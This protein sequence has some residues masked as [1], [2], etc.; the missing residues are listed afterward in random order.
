MSG[1]MS[2]ERELSV[3]IGGFDENFQ[4]AAY[5]FD[6][7]FA[8]RA[9]R[10]GARVRFCPEASLRHLRAERG[11][12]RVHGNHLASA[13]PIHGV[14][15]YYFALLHGWNPSTAWYMARRMVREVATRFHLRHPWFI[16][17]KLVGEVR[18]F[19]WALKLKRQGPR[20]LASGGREPTDPVIL[21]PAQRSSVVLDGT[22]RMN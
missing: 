1:H 2:V 6:T 16:P 13:D 12:T 15:D 9:I 20:H 11:G 14:G 19:L 21:E 17:V 22:S 8:R 4:G 18:A 10:H 5:R 7:E 3:E